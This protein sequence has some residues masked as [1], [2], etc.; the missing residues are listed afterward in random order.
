M[1]R[2]VDVIGFTRAAAVIGLVCAQLS[3]CD[4]L[5][6][7]EAMPAATSARAELAPRPA[8]LGESAWEEA[9]LQALAEPTSV[10]LPHAEWGGFLSH[11]PN[12]RAMTFAGLEGQTLEIVLAMPE[13]E[14][15]TMAALARGSVTAELFAVG[16]ETP[17]RLGTLTQ[18]EAPLMLRLPLDGNYVVRLRPEPNADAIYHIELELGAAL[19]SP[20]RGYAVRDMAVNAFFGARRDG[21]ARSHQGVDLFAPRRTPVL[22]VADGTATYRAND[23]G[24]HSV[25]V[26]APGVSY[27]YAHLERVAVGGGQRVKAGDIIGYVGNSGNAHATEPHLHFGIYEWG[28][29]PIDPLPLLQSHRFED[30]PG[31]E[32][33]PTEPQT[34]W[35]SGCAAR[36]PDSLSSYRVCLALSELIERPHRPADREL[37]APADAACGQELFASAKLARHTIAPAYGGIS[38]RI[39]SLG[40]A[41]TPA[42]AEL[43]AVNG[44][45]TVYGHPPRIAAHAL[46]EATAPLRDASC[47]PELGGLQW[48]C[49]GQRVRH[50]F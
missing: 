15:D 3:G 50:L 24:G 49:N 41:A 6:A 42:S 17:V 23:L 4:G 43:G 13:S 36:F 7:T 19:P 33:E 28:K 10:K 37:C 26:S 12:A 40:G 46:L 39:G 14:K 25:W 9:A 27:Y 44:F 8:Q 22:A 35:R 20:L 2:R 11:E 29:N 5:T 47:A 31:A 18:G 45:R 30:I 34:L 21:G 48:P 32:I 1:L 16:G 38:A